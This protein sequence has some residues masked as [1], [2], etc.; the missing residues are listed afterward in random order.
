MPRYFFD[1]E[2]GGHHRDETGVEC[3]DLGEV[4]AIAMRTLPGIV[5][6]EATES[7]RHVATVIARD[8]EGR[9]VFVTTL[10]LTGVW[11]IPRDDA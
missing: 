2:N 5:G 4:C 1:I 6:E 9:P 3:R 8:E 11:L 10:S 7:R